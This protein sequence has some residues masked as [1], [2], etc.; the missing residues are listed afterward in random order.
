MTPKRARPGD[1]IASALLAAEVDGEQLSDIEFDM[2]FMLLINAGGDTTRNLVAGGML[3]LIEHPEQRARLAADPRTAAVGDRGDAALLHAGDPL[4]PHRDARHR[5]TRSQDRSRSTRW[6][7]STARRIATR[8]SS[9]TPTA[10]TSRARP[11]DHLAFGGGGAHFCLGANLAR[12]E[13]RAMFD[14]VLTR[15]PDLAL[16]GPV[17]RLPLEL[18][19]RPAAHAGAVHAVTHA[20]R[21]RRASIGAI[22][23]FKVS[24]CRAAMRVSCERRD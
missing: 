7:F 3:E 6:W 2:F 23:Q 16:A 10:S 11:N 9:P 8:T 19:Q 22:A 21:G 20:V 15:L 24:S 13:I 4:P 18:H 17:E 12:L 14:Q 5:A 1:D